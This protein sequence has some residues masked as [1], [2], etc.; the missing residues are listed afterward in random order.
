MKIYLINFV[1][2]IQLA[3]TFYRAG[4]SP[5]PIPYTL[6]NIMMYR[7]IKCQEEVK[8]ANR[9]KK[10]K[11]SEKMKVGEKWMATFPPPSARFA[12]QDKPL[13]KR[14]ERGADSPPC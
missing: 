3:P 5:D 4:S 14:Q 13:P 11:W 8:L 9:N 2:I 1:N 6:P 7:Y 12:S 10:L